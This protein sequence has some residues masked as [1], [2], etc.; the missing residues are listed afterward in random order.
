MGTSLLALALLLFAGALAA[1]G[2]VGLG[3][4]LPQNRWIGLR[5]ASLRTSQEAWRAGHRAAGASLVT[6]A[7]PA[8]LLAVALVARPPAAVEDWLL[9]YV[10]V[11]LVSGGLIALASRQADRAA[12]EVTSRD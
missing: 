4:R 7:G 2:I 1:V 3:E 9:I 11:G 8:L 10:A 5:V 12:R 6:A